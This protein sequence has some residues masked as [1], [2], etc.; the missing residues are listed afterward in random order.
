M[1]LSAAVDDFQ[2]A[3]MKAVLTEI[4]AKATGKNADL[5]SYDA[6]RKELKLHNTAIDRGLH[7]IPLDAIIGSAGRYEDFTKGFFPK[8]SSDEGR[9]ARVKMAIESLTG[10]PPIEVYKVDQVY[11]VIDGNHRVSVARQI[12]AE[13]IQARVHEIDVSVHLTPDLDPDDLLLKAEQNDFFRH[14]GLNKLRPQ[15]DFTLT[16]LGMY[17]KLLEH[18]HTHR[19]F[20]GIEQQHPIDWTDA[21]L[22]WCDRVY[23]PV[24]EVI[25]RQGLLRKFPDRSP[26]DMYLWIMEYHDDLEKELGWR[27]KSDVVAANLSTRFSANLSDVL[28]RIRDRI[29]DWMTPDTLESGPEPGSWRRQILAMRGEGS[30][31]FANIL[32]PIK[33]LDSCWGAL[34]QAIL[35]ARMENANILGLHVQTLGEAENAENIERF[36]QRFLTRC[37]EAGVSG[38]FAVER[39]DP[40]RMITER[41]KWADLIIADFC[42]HPLPSLTTKLKAI[43]HTILRRSGR[44]LLAVCSGAVQIRTALLAYDG[45]P[46]AKE[47]LFMAA[48]LSQKHKLPLVVVTVIHHDPKEAEIQIEARKY[49]ASHRVKAKYMVEKGPPAIVIQRIAEEK[50]IDLLIMGSYG[51][52]P[53]FELVLGST[54]DYLLAK[55]NRPILI[56]R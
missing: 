7:E 53:I 31:L 17:Q 12:G 44:P 8:R 27:L 4:L 24:L 46:K 22:H 2:K 39:G 10:V 9:W 50:N 56:C 23:Q 37:Q 43:R 20:M 52:K 51:F 40:A 49:L 15:I 36:K 47:A 21:V 18:I 42:N 45:S 16:A 5:L 6:V 30:D 3:H 25:Q 33:D 48:Y 13:K 26:A 29:Y 41:S 14:T 32:V 34:E 38:D 35:V 1:S 54:V 19:Y 55:G 28:R 11:F